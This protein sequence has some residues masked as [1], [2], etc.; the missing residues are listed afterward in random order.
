MMSKNAW[1]LVRVL[2]IVAAVLGVVLSPAWER[3]APAPDD[4]PPY[5][6]PAVADLFPEDSSVVEAMQIEMVRVM[7]SPPDGRIYL[8]DTA[9]AQDYR[10]MAVDQAWER[11][12]RSYDQTQ[13]VRVVAEIHTIS[14]MSPQVALCEPLA[15]FQVPGASRAGVQVSNESATEACAS[16]DEG[17][18]HFE[19]RV[20][21]TDANHEAR[22]LD[23]VRALVTPLSEQVEPLPDLEWD[24][25][26]P[27]LGWQARRVEMVGLLLLIGAATI[28]GLVTDVPR[29]R[30]L[31]AR[32]SRKPSNPEHVD[33]EPEHGFQATQNSALG[34]V[35]VALLVWALWLTFTVGM[36]ATVVGTLATMLTAYFVG[37]WLQRR[38]STE[39][40]NRRRPRLLRGRAVVPSIV[41]VLGSGLMLVAALAVWVLGN[42]LTSFGSGGGDIATWEANGFGLLLQGLAVV[43]FAWSLAPVILGRRFS[44]ALMRDR[45]RGSS[46][47]TLLLRTFGDDQ[48]RLPIKRRD[49][50]GFLDSLVMK[51]RERFEEILTYT[52]ARYGP[53]IAIGRPGER[54]PPGI[55]GQRFT[56]S[57]ETWQE[58]VRLWSDEAVVICLMVGKT[59]GL[60]W[61]MNHVASNGLLHKTV[62]VVPPVGGPE[63]RE[64][65]RILAD[66]YSLDPDVFD[67]GTKS[68]DVLAFC[69]PLGWSR[70]LVFSSTAA[71]DISYDIALERCAEALLK[72]SP[73]PSDQIEAPAALP[74]YRDI[75]LPPAPP[76]TGTTSQLLPKIWIASIVTSS[77]ALPF[78][79][80]LLTGDPLGSQESLTR[81]LNFRE[82]VTQ[83]SV[84]GGTP[85]ASFAVV[86]NHFLVEGDFTRSRVEVVGEFDARS[87]T[88]ELVDESVVYLGAGVAGERLM[89]AAM[90][91]TSGEHQWTAGLPERAGSVAVTE[92]SVA[93]PQPRSQRLLLWDRATGQPEEPVELPCRPWEASAHGN[94]VWVTCPTEGR[95]LAITD[96]SMETYKVPVGATTILSA[97]DVPYVHIPR[98]SVVVHPVDESFRLWTRQPLPSLD[99][100]GRT[101]AVEGVDRVS[102][103]SPAGLSR[104]NTM[105]P[106]S[107]LSVAED[108]AVQYARYNQWILLLPSEE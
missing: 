80:P 43:V 18:Q 63:R 54:L 33:L 77:L 52:L 15:E 73:A 60:S 82:E 84:L 57:H 28:P 6:P 31:L 22:A 34:T 74:E 106:L 91:V 42:R 88:A 25:S 92:T 30:R 38:L 49:R 69:W 11:R 7:D 39:P 86:D 23:A 2:A 75:G 36:L 64:R 105:T 4:N 79:A 70:P 85:E 16:I 1:N 98:N 8:L 95:L 68:R 35:R 21:T 93:V 97:A 94:I 96:R 45:P 47:P 17:R 83:V 67:P 20:L 55:G 14:S 90:D 12:W 58:G 3:R 51:R 5:N 100:S 19:V 50:V 26:N 99:A 89:V 66:S 41:G 56:F 62:F 48:L 103:L 108:G 27:Q 81:V 40:R 9:P 87:V 46:P 29:W 61:E 76:R 24:G 72:E 59:Q 71:D 78:A 65:L 107:S 102:L 10:R 53:P 32:G 13:E 104:R 101:I 44:M 37:I